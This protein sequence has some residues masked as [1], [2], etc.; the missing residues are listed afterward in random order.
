MQIARDGFDGTFRQHTRDALADCW[1][2][3]SHAQRRH[4]S[5]E[6]ITPQAQAAAK[7]LI[8]D[9]QTVGCIRLWKPAH[10]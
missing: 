8:Q 9:V 10:G 4:A 6:K 1:S 2:T 5:T 3:V 7:N